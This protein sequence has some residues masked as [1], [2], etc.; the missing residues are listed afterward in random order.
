MLG[1]ASSTEPIHYVKNESNEFLAADKHLIW[2]VIVLH[3]ELNVPFPP[4][5]QGNRIFYLLTNSNWHLGSPN[6]GCIRGFLP[7][8]NCFP[9]WIRSLWAQWGWCRNPGTLCPFWW[10]LSLDFGHCR[11]HCFDWDWSR[12]WKFCLS[13]GL[14]VIFWAPPVIRKDKLSGPRS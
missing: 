11:H 6:N 5:M 4:A 1:Q 8:A 10:S 13:L 14:F 9:W 7:L 2:D 3:S 12:Q